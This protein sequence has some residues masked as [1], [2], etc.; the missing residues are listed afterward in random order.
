VSQPYEIAPEFLG[1]VT[2]GPAAP[3]N[4]SGVGMQQTGNQS[5]QAGFARAVRTF[6]Q[7]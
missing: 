3:E 6:D 4:V 2:H 5:Q 1:T 7:Q